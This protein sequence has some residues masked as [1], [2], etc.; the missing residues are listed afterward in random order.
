MGSKRDNRNRKKERKKEDGF[1][2]YKKKHI[3]LNKMLALQKE[4]KK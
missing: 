4:N 1:E 2:R 3:V